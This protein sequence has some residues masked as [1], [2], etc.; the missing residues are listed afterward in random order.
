M[1][2]T[3]RVRL[4]PPSGYVVVAAVPAGARNIRMEEL[5]GT[6]EGS[7]LAVIGTGLIADAADAS[8]DA[9]DDADDDG[10]T[11]DA[12]NDTDLAAVHRTGALNA[13]K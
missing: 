9:S 7:F 5:E 11:D 6:G 3:E 4:C 12:E 2:C 13:N 1:W 10:D 8:D